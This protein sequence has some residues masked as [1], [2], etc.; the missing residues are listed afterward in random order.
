[1][2][3]ISSISMVLGVI[4][5]LSMIIPATV[6][7]DKPPLGIHGSITIGNGIYNVTVEDIGPGNGTY[8]V[9]TASNH[10]YPNQSVLYGGATQYPGTSYLTVRDYSNGNIEY[11][12]RASAPIASSGFTVSSLDPFHFS[13]TQSGNKVYTVWNISN[14]IRIN[15]TITI[16][17]TTYADSRVRVSTNITNT[18]PGLLIV[19]IRY[20]WD[21]MIDG[22]DGS[23]FAQRNPDGAWLGTENTWISP[24]FEQYELINDPNSPIFSILGTVNGPASF[25]PPPTPPD[26]LMFA[27]WGSTPAPG[28]YD[29]AFDF[30]TTG[31][32][33]SGTNNDSSVVY[34]WGN[35]RTNAKEISTYGESYE[36]TQYL[37]VTEPP[38]PG[39]CGVGGNILPVDKIELLWPYVAMILSAVMLVAIAII[40][41]RYGKKT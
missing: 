7:A 24:S 31:R 41:S 2:K 18:Y 13:T 40:G 1:M 39:P 6:Q 8:T 17:G 22:E 29:Y 38:S 9:A 36:V 16:E 14:I 21:L 25:V 12:S 19:G 32:Q 4:L 10:P 15:Q 11:Y 26:A 33:I 23:W 27:A 28:V 34:Y 3:K 35:N 37:Y 20:E 30:T 5:F